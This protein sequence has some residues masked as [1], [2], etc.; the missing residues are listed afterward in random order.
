MN[1]LSVNQTEEMITYIAENMIKKEAELCE[2][3]GK[4]GDGDHG[5]GIARGFRSVLAEMDNTHDDVK[6][7]FA[8][9]GFEM[10]NSMGGAS[11]IVFSSIFLGAMTESPVDSLTVS[12]LKNYLENGLARVKK[13]GGAQWGDKTMID[14]FEPAVEQLKSYTGEDLVEAFS[15]LAKAA[16]QGAENTRNYVAKFGRAKFLGERSLGSV[17]AGAVS[18]SLIFKFGNEYLLKSKEESNV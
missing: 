7:V 3:D 16:D 1:C 2:L 15:I 11:G 4:I 6:A 18:V 9:A 14:A 5:I 8:N 12:N 13:K 17:D 10:M